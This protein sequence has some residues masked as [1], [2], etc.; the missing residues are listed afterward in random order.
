MGSV[1]S[2]FSIDGQPPVE[3]D[4]YA[5][6]LDQE[7]ILLERRTRLAALAREHNDP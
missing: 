5:S 6:I 4:A 3:L 1:D 7:E 2:P